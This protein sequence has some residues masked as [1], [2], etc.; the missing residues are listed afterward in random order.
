MINL[1]GRLS[2]VL[3]CG[4]RIVNNDLTD[5]Y[6][7]FHIIMV[8]HSVNK[9]GLFLSLLILENARIVRETAQSRILQ[10]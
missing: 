1:I 3:S 2:Y 6:I 10:L 4:G 7:K 8:N 9:H 5:N